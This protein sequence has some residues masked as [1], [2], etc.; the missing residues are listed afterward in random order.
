MIFDPIKHLWVRLTIR[1]SLIQHQ[2]II[3]HLITLTVLG[4]CLLPIPL[5]AKPYFDASLILQYQ[6]NRGL[7]QLESISADNKAIWLLLEKI[8]NTEL[9]NI[10]D[11]LK[12]HQAQI[13]HL[14]DSINAKV[15]QALEAKLPDMILVQTNKDGDLEISPKLYTYLQD[16][17]SWDNFLQQNNK[18]IS[19]YISGEM[20]YFFEQQEKQGAIVN[21]NTFMKLLA[22]DLIHHQGP[23]AENAEVSFIELVNNA[24]Q[25]YHQDVLNTADFAL[26]S[27]G[28]SI[29]ESLTSP[30]F[31][32]SPTWKRTLRHFIG[33][34]EHV[35]SP[36]FAITS[37]THAGECWSMLG[38]HGNLTI[39]LSEPV[40]IQSVTLEYPSA[41]IMMDNMTT[42]PK[43]M[44]VYGLNHYHQSTHPTYLGHFTYDIN[45]GSPIQT[46]DIISPQENTYRAISFKVLSNW[47]SNERTDIYRIRVHG[48][49]EKN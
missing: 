3:K 25:N 19:K 37:T 45:K 40:I 43:E 32:S 7:S 34:H 21:K 41:E 4:L 47:G 42:A 48:R 15:T 28:A 8:Q 44:S 22:N 23:T 33:L 39:K 10:W 38:S 9:K 14:R 1:G 29:L 2:K 11:K 26:E 12:D 36:R 18:S 49:P 30:T 17:V 5:I 46:F 27:R 31:Y 20:S 16:T 35:N 6:P 24:I 13:N